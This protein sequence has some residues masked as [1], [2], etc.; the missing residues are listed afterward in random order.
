M[1]LGFR[2]ALAAFCGCILK[3]LISCIIF[4]AVLAINLGMAPFQQENVVVIEVT[5]SIQPIMAVHTVLPKSGLVFIHE[6]GVMG[7]VTGRAGFRVK[8]IR[9][10]LVTILA[11]QSSFFIILGVT[12]QAEAGL[13]IVA[14]G[15]SIEKGGRPIFS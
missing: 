11:A 8:G 2:M 4:V 12:H 9:V 13:D 7:R 3:N 1:N 15:F 5:H 14:K 10:I 6:I